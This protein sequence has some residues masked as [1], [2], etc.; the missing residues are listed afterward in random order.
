MRMSPSLVCVLLAV[1]WSA[2]TAPAQS[3]P[4]AP[5][6]SAPALAGQSSPAAVAAKPEDKTPPDPAQDKS[7][8][9][10]DLGSRLLKLATE[11]KAQVDKTSKDTLSLDVIRK[12]TEIET[13]AHDA[14]TGQL[15]PAP[16]GAAK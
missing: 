7:T 5:V 3:A 11:L 10:A 1:A 13:L 8:P 4:A 16:T 14:R 15:A 12:A 2:Q 9:L 6:Q